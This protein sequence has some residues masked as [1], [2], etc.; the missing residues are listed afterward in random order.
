MGRSEKTI[1]TVICMIYDGGRILLQDRIKGDWRGFFFPGGHV[2]EGEPFVNAVVREIKE[3]TGLTIYNPQIC[4]VKQFGTEDGARYVVLLYKTDQFSGE[5][6]SSEEGE[7]VWI[8]RAALR[9][10][11]VADSFFETLR[12]YDDASVTEL[13]YEY[14]KGGNKWTAK[15]Y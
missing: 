7:M 11:S 8:D 2:E 10:I 13:F 4:G 15:F 9:D 12:V 5:L 14:D 3:E 6:C 1:L